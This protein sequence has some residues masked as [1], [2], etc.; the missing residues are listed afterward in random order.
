[1]LYFA[2]SGLFTAFSVSET[3]NTVPP[4]LLFFQYWCFPTFLN[5]FMGLKLPYKASRWT[6]K[7]A[8]AL[9][10]PH[11]PY[12]LLNIY[13]SSV[14]PGEQTRMLLHPLDFQS[15]A[16]TGSWHNQSANTWPMQGWG[17]NE[18]SRVQLWEAEGDRETSEC[19][20]LDHVK[21]KQVFWSF[22]YLSHCFEHGY[23]HI[24][25]VAYEILPLQVL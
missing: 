7:P 18:C 12:D 2:A 21:E 11:Q 17:H 5:L 14:S 10:T 3:L 9:L 20:A 16:L 22:H 15:L 23:Y 19:V 4:N 8:L 6:W 13:L 24:W 1:M 25:K